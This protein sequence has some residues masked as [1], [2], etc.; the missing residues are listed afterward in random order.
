M[1]A[2]SAYS[3]ILVASRAPSVQSH[4][5]WL[6]HINSC[7]VQE[8]QDAHSVAAAAGDLSFVTVNTCCR[9]GKLQQQVA[10]FKPLPVMPQ[11]DF[12]T[13]MAALLGVPAPF[14][15][16]GKLFHDLWSVGHSLDEP[17]DQTAFA[18]A[19]QSNAKQVCTVIHCACYSMSKVRH[20]HSHA[21]LHL[22][23]HAL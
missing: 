20:R 1:L 10:Q 15:S 12:A 5:L 7:T 21:G 23:I 2:G 8:H 11:V 16:I 14:G 4:F 13:T 18:Q 17:A 6:S 3:F 19:L 9:E 22:A